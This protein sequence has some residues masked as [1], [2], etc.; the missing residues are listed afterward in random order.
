MQAHRF[1]RSLKLVE[2]IWNAD[3]SDINISDSENDE[4]DDDVKDPSFAPPDLQCDSSSEE[5]I[6]E[7]VSIVPEISIVDS[8]LEQNIYCPSTGSITPKR[9]KRKKKIS[10][11]SIS[12][13]STPSTIDVP[14]ISTLKIPEKSRRLYWKNLLSEEFNLLP[15]ASLYIENSRYLPVLSLEDYF[16]KYIPNDIIKLMTEFTNCGY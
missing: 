1:S 15:P 13:S 4:N 3:E 5:E 7:E 10:K 9:F 11:S 14:N 6:N 16:H 12:A 2:E 8:V